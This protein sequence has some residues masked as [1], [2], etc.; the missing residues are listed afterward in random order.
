[1]TGSQGPL[2]AALADRYRIER[3]LGRGGMATVYLAQ[4]LKHNRK[5]A[6]KVL[7][8]ELAAVLG[9]ERF[10]REINIAANL[11]SP[12]I[13][14]LLDSGE[15]DG[16]L[17][18]VMPYVKGESLR[19]RLARDGALPP[20]EALRLLREITDGVAHAHR[21]GVIHRDIKPDNVM[22]AEGH[23]LLMDFGV[24][25]ALAATWGDRQAGHAAT[26]TD[27]GISPGTPA[28][29]APEQAAADPAVDHRADLYAL[30]AMAYEMLT[31]R[32][33]F[34]GS[35]QA[36]MAAHIT[37]PPPALPATIPTGVGALV[38][39]CLAKRPQDRYPTA[40]ALLE[41]VEAQLST[42]GPEARDPGA[43]RRRTAITL[44]AMVAVGVLAFLGIRRAQRSYW[45]RGTA[46]PA[47]KRMIDDGQ[48]DSAWYLGLRARGVV[49]RD[50]TLAGLFG[51][52]S[53]NQVLPIVTRPAGA[54]V[55]RASLADTSI[56]HDLGT[57]PIESLPLP[58]QIGLFRFKKP[59]YRTLYT[60]ATR[61]YSTLALD[62]ADTPDSDMITVAGDSGYGTF[63]VGT[64]GSPEL[65]LGDWK[66]ARYET[67]NRE[68]KAFVD[69]GGYRDSTWWDLPIRDGNRTLS[70]ARAQAR[71]VDQTGRP[72][73]STWVAGDYP[74]GQGEMPVGGVSWYEAAAFARWA[75]KSLPTVYHW[76]Q[77]SGIWLSRAMVPLSNMEGS[78]PWK[79]G[80][81]RGVSA[82]GASDMA[83]NVREWNYNAESASGARY[84]L[85]GGWSDPGYAFVD[86]YA[87]P[88]MDRSAINGIR[89]AQYTPA[90]SNV[91]LARR[92]LRRAFT[93]YT[94]VS[95]VPDAV[96]EGYRHQFDYDPRPLDARIE[97]ADSSS[98]E[99][100]AQFVSYTAA[101]GGDRMQAWI[102][103]PKHGSPPFQAVVFFPGS[104][105]INTRTSAAYRD[106]TASFVV[107]SGRAF[108]LPIYQSTYERTDSLTSDIPDQ[109]I[110]WRDHVVMWGKDYRR[111][112][113]YLSGRP[114]IDST[115][116]AYF[117]FSWGG[118][119][120][121]IVPAIE[122]RL[123]A[124]VL[125]VAGLTMERSRPEVDPINYLPRVRIPVIMLNGKY[126]FFF[127]TETAQRPFF[128][129]LG[130]PAVEK[131]WVVYDGGHDV[132]RPTLIAETFAWLDKYLGPVRPQ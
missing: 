31:G 60:M 85:G 49:P 22:L 14:P 124:A 57:T 45:V 96:F 20:A 76:A 65:A 53:R 61:F 88:P 118:N 116:V 105:A 101:Y 15:A 54:R 36:V 1:M 16:L 4:D 86:A 103:L 112:L 33:P 3:E 75:E 130:T 51:Q 66:I 50:S 38:L 111:T 47:I 19:D 28:Y 120:G 81:P 79:V 13:L 67:T 83:G 27:V 58:Y 114:D 122:P 80:T 12:H 62:R 55:Y 110:F 21:H 71:F 63:M 93:D 29:M 131:K 113:D 89:L 10:L 95:S 109:S 74:A 87:Q 37:A 26:L 98:D 8:P 132:P 125:Y 44:L 106:M 41:A 126:D 91:A 5:V 56:W 100:N 40:D 42:G 43:R 108:V 129:R 23:A 7:K 107:K 24:A 123:K 99:W 34:T 25:K 32:P 46:I 2:A 97:R 17:Y 90:D 68:Y 39:R 104:G 11:Q 117:G 77:A 52:L 119:M 127:P 59:G 121:G 84:I 18:Y 35:P 70:W 94:R 6:I 82:V 48:L 115:R 102:F 69:A 92:P 72:G 78:G 9:A 64:D 73:P 128:E 30:G